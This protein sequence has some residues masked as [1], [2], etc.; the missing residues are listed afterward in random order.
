MPRLRTAEHQ[1][2][3][4]GGPRQDVFRQ[5]P[6]AGRPKWLHQR[7]QLRQLP[8]L[9]SR[10]PFLRPAFEHLQGQPRRRPAA[11]ATTA[12][13]PISP[14]ARSMWTSKRRPATRQLG[15]RINWWVRKLYI[16]MIFVVVGLMAVH[17]A[18]IFGRK[19]ALLNRRSERTLMRMDASRNA[20]NISSLAASFIVAGLDRFCLEVSRF[21]GRP[22][23]GLGRI[24]RRWSPSH[25]RGRAPAGRRVSCGLRLSSCREGRRLVKDMM[26][27]LKDARDAAANVRRLAGLGGVKP[28]FARFGYAEKMEYWAVVWGTVIMGATG[29]MIWFKMEVT[30]FLPRWAV[31]VA[32]TIHYYEA[33]LACLAI[34]VWHFYHVI[35]DPDV[36]PLNRAVLDGRVSRQWLEEE[37]PLD[38]GAG[39][40]GTGRGGPRWPLAPA[41]SRPTAAKMEKRNVRSFESLSERKF[42]PWPS[43]WRKRTR[44]SMTT[45]PKACANTIPSRPPS[46]RKCAATRKAIA[47]GSSNFFKHVSATTCPWSGA[48]TSAG[49]SSAAPSGWI[50][51]LS[52]KAARKTGGIDGAGNRA[53]LRGL[54]PRARPM[55]ASGNCWAIWPPRSATT[56]TPPMQ[57]G[58]APIERG[59]AG[60]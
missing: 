21:L 24:V 6:R 51:P 9:P 52:L 34:L 7:R 36:Y 27:R 42:F 37:H 16:A 5:L 17:N 3:S 38:P 18:L 43:R 20:G 50:G 55:R 12:P 28:K 41:A 14:K 19:A 57:L 54:R 40:R 4:A 23:P 26:P 11:N 58:Q 15:E 45:S 8:R 35:F 13:A 31:D 56:P 39:R 30:R 33:I 60:P 46:S 25:R 10:S 32:T 59:E 47:G 22:F 48:R 1:I 29:L 2:Q 53:L 44:R 49:S